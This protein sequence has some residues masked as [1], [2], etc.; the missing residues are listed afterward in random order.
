MEQKTINWKRMCIYGVIMIALVFIT[1][2]LLFKDYSLA[3]AKEVLRRA[4]LRFAGLGILSMCLFS[5]CE[6]VVIRILLKIFNRRLPVSRSVQYAFA[7]FYFSSITPS[8]TGGQPMQFYYMTRDGIGGA[9]ATFTLLTVTASYQMAVLVYGSLSALLKFDY[10]RSMPAV[11]RWLIVFGI[12]ANGLAALFILMVIFLRK[13][14]EGVVHRV[15]RFLHRIHVIRHLEK[16]EQKMESIMDEYAQGGLYLRKK[17]GV[18]LKVMGLTFLQLTFLYFSSYCACL[19][20]GIKGVSVI[21][22]IMMQ[23]VLSLAVSA[24]PLPGSVGASESAFLFLFGGLFTGSQLLPVMMMARGISFYSFL[25]VTGLV[26]LHLQF[27]RRF[28]SW[29]MGGQK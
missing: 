4:D 18:F 19:A 2:S 16:A 12:L 27:H 25:V 23:A 8:A 21:S 29:E 15:L 24:V 22:F 3:E 13:P 6:A 5:C 28:F 10:I 14:V 26:V 17:P 1:F 11:V 9:Q 7:G 20:L